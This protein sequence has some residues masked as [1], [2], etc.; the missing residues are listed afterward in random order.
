[1]WIF[2]TGGFY[3]AVEV[4]ETDDLLVRTRDRESAQLAI[5]G[6]ETETGEEVELVTGEGTDY[7]YR[8]KV[9]REN[10]AAWVS[11]EVLRYIDYTNFK[12]AS[13][14]KG[15]EWD[16]ALADVWRAMRGV[17]EPEMRSHGWYGS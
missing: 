15:Q 6:I 17:T 3:S 9:S 13:H 2:T 16:D 12:A 10:F 1:M 11:V 4:P 7:P 14:G 5:D 8:F